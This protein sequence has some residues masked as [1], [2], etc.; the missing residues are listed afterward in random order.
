MRARSA[1][2]RH[3]GAVALHADELA[4]DAAGHVVLV[5]LQGADGDQVVVVAERDVGGPTPGEVAPGEVA[6]LVDRLD[7]VVV[8]VH[9]I[10]RDLDRVV[11]VA[12]EAGTHL[13]DGVGDVAVLLGTPAADEGDIGRRVVDLDRALQGAVDRDVG[14]GDG[15]AEA[16]D[17]LDDA[18]HTQ[19]VHDVLDGLVQF[20]EEEALLGPVVQERT[21]EGADVERLTELQRGHRLSS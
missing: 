16:V 21:G 20:L 10:L 18:E 4:D 3:V 19:E 9:T 17:S 7:R 8:L 6:V 1:L 13:A 2:E 5:L 15:E 14:D 11:L 12:V